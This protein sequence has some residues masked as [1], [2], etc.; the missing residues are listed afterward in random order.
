MALNRRL[1]TLAVQPLL[2][3]ATLGG[4]MTACTPAP[5]PSAV[6]GGYAPDGTVIVAEDGLVHS[7]GSSGS[8][9]TLIQDRL[10][11]LG[12]FISDTRGT[13]GYGTA[14][15]VT[16]FQKVQGLTRDGQAGPTTKWFLNHPG[17]PV[18]ASTS[19]RVIEVQLAKQVVLLVENGKVKW[20][21]DASSGASATPTPKGRYS[22]YRQIDGYR[23]APL[24]TLYRPKYFNGGIA[25]HGSSSVPT[26]P[27]SHGCVRLTNAET[28]FLWTQ[29]WGAIG[30]RVW[31]Y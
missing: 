1:R 7:R 2:A 20:I 31:V 13:F 6:S 27:A 4:L 24:G 16:A 30:T 19:G 14:H 23:H 26:Y 17:I 8:K 21:F 12:Y 5:A 3:V 22:I 9:V 18:G 10:V 28:D 11:Q 15:A 25:L 29:P